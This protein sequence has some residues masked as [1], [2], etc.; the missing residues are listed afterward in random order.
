MPGPVPKRPDERIRRNEDVVP[1]DK[2]EVY[3]EVVVPPLNLPF[4]PHPMVVD[5]YDGLIN[6][7]QAQFYE[8]S[9]WE[10]ARV[11]CFMLQTLVT[12]SKPSSEMY[13]AWQ[14]ATSNLLVTEGDRRRLRIEIARKAVTDQVDDAS[15]ALILQFKERMEGAVKSRAEA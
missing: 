6:S 8:P 15:E 2:I 12:S 1:T 9:D 5:F 13:K 4:D 10:Y 11:V 14:T 3:G 7:A